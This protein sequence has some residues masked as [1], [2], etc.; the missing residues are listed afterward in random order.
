MKTRIT[1]A[2]EGP[3]AA[4]QNIADLLKGAEMIHEAVYTTEVQTHSSLETHGASIDH[5]GDSATAYVSTQGTSAARDGLEEALGLPRGKFEVVCEYVGGGFGSKLNGAGKE[6]TTAARVGAKYKRPVY[7][8]CDREEDHLDTGNRPSARADV[9]IGFKKDG[10]ILGGLVNCWGA[11]GVAKGGAGMTFPS[12]RYELGEIKKNHADVQLNAGAPR[13]FRAPGH[14]QGA[15]IEELVLDEIATKAGVDPL[16]LRL[17][18]SKDADRSEMLQYA[19][20]LI[21]WKDRRATGS[22]KGIL[23]RG[24]GC[25]TCVWGAP[26]PGASA[27]VVIH[28]DGSVEPRTGTQDIGT[29]QRTTMGICAANILGIPLNLVNV[30]IGRSSLPPGPGSGGS[31]TSP[32]TAP[33]MMDA[34]MDA[35]KKFLEMIASQAGADA[36]EFDIAAGSIVRNTKQFMTWQQAC[37]KIAG[38]SIVGKSENAKGAAGG[39]GKGHSNG[40]QFVEL[41]VDTE[42]GVIRV[43][44]V[45]A[46]QSGG[47]VICR[48]TAESQIIGGV[49]Q[50]LSYG[51][52][53]QRV[54][55]RN[56]GSMLNANLDMYKILGPNDMPHI[57]PILWHKGQTGVRSI[58]EP[59][60]VPTAAAVACAVLNAI[61]KP[62][63]SLPMTPDRVLAALQGA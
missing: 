51:L 44:R 16:E 38:D 8:F 37:A 32:I 9:K 50:G 47:R 56:F 13:P 36:S 52:Y 17:K 12:G 27:E 49:I 10:T 59:P 62:V 7:L 42:T 18:L 30:S 33:T 11:S 3:E 45:I 40:A 6:G 19:S 2:M 48:K 53:E 54:L 58:G 46:I 60:V 28:R 5:R 41:E 1:D 15:F 29:G 34:A 35:R 22:Q 23:R 39:A 20:K 31:V 25:A 26:P 24:F 14:P 55:D 43:L 4:P 63:R 21:G 57:E 61:G